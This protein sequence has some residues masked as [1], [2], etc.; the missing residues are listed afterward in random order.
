MRISCSRCQAQ[1]NLPD[2]KLG[3]GAAKIRCKQ[4]GH[5]FVVK[6][7]ADEPTPVEP[8]FDDFDFA[9]ASNPVAAGPAPEEVGPE[10][11]PPPPDTPMEDE[12]AP[13]A[14]PVDGEEPGD[15]DFSGFD[16]APEPTPGEA[17]PAFGEV[18]LSLPDF[19]APDAGSL[20]A[21]DADSLF[22]GLDAKDFDLLG[23]ESSFPLPQGASAAEGSGLSLGPDT[24]AAGRPPPGDTGFDDLLFN[25][26]ETNSAEGSGGPKAL[27]A[28]DKEDFFSSPDE[29]PSLGELDL[30]EFGDGGGG[31]GLGEAPPE[32]PERV[33][34][35][36]LVSP[37]RASRDASPLGALDEA[38]RLDLQKGPR[39]NEPGA[40]P[41]PLVARDRRRSPLAW[42]V[43][44]AALAT[45]GYTAYNAYWHPE[46]LTFLNPSRVRELW[47]SRDVEARFVA[48]GV[49]G[50]A[51]DVPG[52]RVFVIQGRV[53]NKS[54]APQSLI[55]VK[56]NLFG[57]GGAATA[58]SEVY[59]GNVL[60]KR[61]L[62]ALPWA[63]VEA[64][65]QNQVG[66]ALS[67]VDIAPGAKVP[68]MLVFRSPAAKVE[69]FN[70]LVSAWR[71][72]TGP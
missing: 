64:R 39:R 12:V 65:L 19:E 23:E 32:P 24:G 44:A 70:V 41:S 45:A 22:A 47:H 54:G 11:V 57:P 20:G 69:N 6:R 3:R 17:A 16:A 53:V 4:C 42:V 18:D 33:R 67:N 68:F 38:P 71:G 13:L 8:K 2:E 1:Y 60:D 72:G 50:Y 43:L 62:A 30:G 58:T 7:R 34:R 40:R 25:S 21:L 46:A 5:V 36:D 52:R 28:E 55:R 26:F 31:F 51:L 15:A 48:E 66:E 14:R 35:E 29:L 37:A 61:E 9:A 49:Q 59:C 10:V 56:G 63:T 27:S